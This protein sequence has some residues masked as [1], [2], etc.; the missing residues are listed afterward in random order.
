MNLLLD[1]AS[2]PLARFDYFFDRYPKYLPSENVVRYEDIFS[3]N[4]KVLK[5]VIPVAC[6]LDVW[7]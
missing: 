2:R 4:G 1:P 7:G 5:V 6:R 3:S